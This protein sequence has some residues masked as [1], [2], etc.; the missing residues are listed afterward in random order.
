MRLKNLVIIFVLLFVASPNFVQ[1]A[2]VWK[3]Y[4]DFEGKFDYIEAEPG[5]KKIP[6]GMKWIRF[7]PEDRLD[8]EIEDGMLWFFV[9]AAGDRDPGFKLVFGWEPRDITG[10]QFTIKV[11]DL[12]KAGGWFGIL[13]TDE[14]PNWK[15]SNWIFGVSPSHQ[16]DWGPKTYF[17]SGSLG[18]FGGWES[19]AY[20]DIPEN[21]NILR[22]IRASWNDVEHQMAITVDPGK[23]TFWK[24]DDVPSNAEKGRVSVVEYLH[25]L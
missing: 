18:K 1:S 13:C 23:K 19:F 9:N 6:L 3:P 4:D 10:I 20:E 22:T 14:E 17:G 8:M 12:S 7:V 16:H 5:Q 21:T 11:A 25:N 24:K 2:K 15:S